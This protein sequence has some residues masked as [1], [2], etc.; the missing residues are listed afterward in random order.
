MIALS[1]GE[2]Y[3]GASNEDRNLRWPEGEL[4]RR[5][6][7]LHPP[8]CELRWSDQERCRPDHEIGLPPKAAVLS[9]RNLTT[10]AGAKSRLQAGVPANR[11]LLPR[12]LSSSFPRSR[13]R[14]P[15]ARE[16]IFWP[17]DD[18]RTRR[19]ACAPRGR[20]QRGGR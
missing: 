8:E 4:C 13:P 20:R 3:R 16:R 15:C 2:L 7:G 18:R 9:A 17:P 19:V 5:D 6:H 1:L 10:R 12:T 11:R 14:P